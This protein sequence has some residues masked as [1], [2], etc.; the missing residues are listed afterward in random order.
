[1]SRRVLALGALALLVFSSGC[2]GP[3]GGGTID[4]SQLNKG[5]PEGGYEWNTSRDAHITVTSDATFHA[6]Y[7]TN[8]SEVELFRRDGFGSREPL[9]VRG[10]RFRYPN[11]TVVKGSEFDDRG[12]DVSRTRQAVVVKLPEDAN[13]GK[14]AF[15][16]DS[17]PKR[18]SLPTFVKG[19]YEVVL[20]PDRRVDFFLFGSVSPAPSEKPV[21]DGRQHIRW[22]NVQSDS[23]TV[24]FYRQRDLGIFAGTTAVLGVVAIAG[25]AYY[26]RKIR[27]LREKREEMGFDVE[28][29]EDYGDGPPGKG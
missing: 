29:D 13:R 10:V 16:A 19:S 15:T 26:R 2:L 24:Q 21:V 6:V 14:L 9:D 20:P 8:K 5:A 18:F 4:D 23:L 25:L 1:M 7:Q 28:V 3:F 12:G 22:E 17:T 11:G 27:R